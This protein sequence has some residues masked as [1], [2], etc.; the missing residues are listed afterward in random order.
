[1]VCDFHSHV[2]YNIDDG[3]KNFETSLAMLKKSL[4]HGVDAVVL[5]SHCYPR[6]SRDIDK[7]LAKRESAYTRLCMESGL[8]KLY[9]ACEVH[10]MQDLTKFSNLRNL[11]I[12]NTNYMLL[13]MPHAPWTDKIIENVY[14]LTIRGII[15]IIAHNERNMHQKQA[16][17][18][19]LYDLNVLIQINAPSI[20]RY[21]YRKRIDKMMRLGLVHV[22]GTDMHNL[23]TR[24]P[25]M[26][27]A[28]KIIKR[29]YGEECWEYMMDNS[30]KIL[31]G[32]KISFL[33]FKS[34][35]K[36]TVF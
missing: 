17:L 13:E 27:K 33:D 18:D 28:Q 32:E 31:N 15:P 34:F 11:C 30:E 4:E 19:S 25:C 1:M 21:S 5:T 20:L 10:L 23:K 14:K 16:M 22:I 24:K 36:K 8:P 26:N 7:F 2:L 29:R 12:E 3:A 6:S 9:K 35:R